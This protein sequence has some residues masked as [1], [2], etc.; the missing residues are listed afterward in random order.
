MKKKC[1]TGNSNCRHY[2]PDYNVGFKIVTPKKGEHYEG[3]KIEN[4]SLIFMLE[5]EVVF[6]YND[7]LNRHFVKGDIFFVPQAAEMYTTALA[8]SRILVLTFNQRTES[9]CDR[10]R[11]SQESRYIPEIRYD[12]RPL[13]ITDTLYTFIALMEEYIEK[14][15]RC[16]YL[17]EL[18]QKELFVLMG[19]EYSTR[20][21]VELFYP[22]SG[23][24]VDFKSRI[25]ENYHSDIEVAELAKRFGMS[26]SAFLRRF[27]KEFGETVQEWILQQKAKHI[28]LKISIPGTN[29]S[30]IIQEFNFSDVSHFVKFCRKYYDCTPSELIKSIRES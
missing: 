26:Y 1:E 28:K 19:A 10:C 7:Y 27:K 16:S 6:S 2:I 20:D 29:I 15:I 18:K 14:Q 22:V 23:G 25:L 8:D 13:V 3:R 11:I 21:L 30:D 5:G 17:H 9:L 12:F 24:N 4:H